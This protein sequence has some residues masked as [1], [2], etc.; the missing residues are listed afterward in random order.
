MARGARATSPTRWLRITWNIIETHRTWTRIILYLYKNFILTPI[1]FK[2][3]GFS[4]HSDSV[5][6][7]IKRFKTRVCSSRIIEYF[8][9]SKEIFMFSKFFEKIIINYLIINFFKLKIT[10]AQKTACV[11]RHAWLLG[12]EHST[13][14]V[15]L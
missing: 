9:F 1:F 14:L 10:T 13:L 4:I 5:F 8:I 3:Y 2:T 11:L 12:E 6:L 7:V 15:G